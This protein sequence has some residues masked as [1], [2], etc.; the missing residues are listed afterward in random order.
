M[1]AILI[2]NKPGLPHPLPK[3]YNQVFGV[4]CGPIT[5]ITL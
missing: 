1:D 3:S 2:C 5:V 4:V